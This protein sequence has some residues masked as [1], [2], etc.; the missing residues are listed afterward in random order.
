MA[1]FF[2]FAFILL[3]SYVSLR[4]GVAPPKAVAMV[5]TVGSVVSMTLFLIVE[6]DATVLYGLILGI[7]AGV[8]FSGLTMGLAV[9]FHAGEAQS[10]RQREEYWQQNLP[11][12]DHEA[13]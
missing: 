11:G 9:F 5:S 6:R 8:L 12:D 3:I 10:Q 2:L 4:R 7:I 13:V 1:F